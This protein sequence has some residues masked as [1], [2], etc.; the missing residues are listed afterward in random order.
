MSDE[1]EYWCTHIIVVS[2]CFTGKDYEIYGKHVPDS[3]KYC[4]E[5]G[6]PRP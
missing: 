3:W 5:C 2:M 1:K 6:E 4:P